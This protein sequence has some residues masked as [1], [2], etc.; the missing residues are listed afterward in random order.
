[1][2]LPSPWWLIYLPV[3]LLVLAPLFDI[4][5]HRKGLPELPHA[6]TLAV[7]LAC[8]AIFYT[9]AFSLR[10]AS[11]V[12]CL[13][14]YGQPGLGTCFI[15]ERAGLF[16]ASTALLLAITASL[17]S[18]SRGPAFPGYGVAFTALVVGMLGVA[19]AGDLLTLYV[20][21]EMMCLSAYALV[22]MGDVRERAL[23][24]AWKYFIMASA[25]A[26]IM[27]IGAAIAYGLAG[28]LN[29]LLLAGL[30]A[31]GAPRAWLYTA[32]VLFILG[33]GVEA[34]IFPLHTW[35][36]DA[37]SEAPTPVS[38]TIAGITTEMGLYGLLKILVVIFRAVASVWQQVLAILCVA[39]MFL[40]NLCA[41]VQDDIKRLLAYSSIG[42][43]GYALAALVALSPSALAAVLFLI[44]SHA[45]SKSLAFLS[46][47]P[48]A[49]G[50]DSRELT[51]LGR[52]WSKAPAAWLALLLALTCRAGLPATSGFVEKLLLL[53]AIFSSPFWWLGLVM[54]VNVVIAAAA[55]F[56]P[57]FIMLRSGLKALGRGE[58]TAKAPQEGERTGL[59][60]LLAFL[61]L[62]LLVLAVG[63]WPSPV[64][65]LAAE[66]AEDL[67]SLGGG[68]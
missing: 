56:R 60:E 24:A 23:E 44:F 68:R 41:L 25:G 37:Y 3:L 29:L 27:L 47:G 55:Y 43:I 42:V 48:L 58:L 34:A 18:L 32:L 59:G 38:A 7:S 9:V 19:L 63:I 61:I 33:M 49:S 16:M 26:I 30:S 20:F 22:A 51:A 40:G 35:L 45:I 2:A 36:P 17:F 50:A 57:V 62:G 52:S 14:A 64:A 1:M 46:A 5:G 15:V 10:G 13:L 53:S 21:W 31:R 12:L 11:P 6:F 28:T 54:V 67:L 65:E 66:G 39:N 4:A 8:A